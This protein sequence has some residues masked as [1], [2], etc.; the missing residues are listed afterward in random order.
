MS[1]EDKT[2]RTRI[3][4]ARLARAEFKAAEAQLERL[5]RAAALREQEEEYQYHQESR[6]A[7]RKEQTQ[8]DTLRKE[9]L[10]PSF[11]VFT[12]IFFDETEEQ[13]ACQH[14]GV[15]AYGDTP[16]LACENFDHL[17]MFGK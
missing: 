15:T 17:W 9:R 6:A 14:C 10:R 4:T 12:E 3:L 7:A 11:A 8:D 1:D 5:Q 13:W 16:D 2:L